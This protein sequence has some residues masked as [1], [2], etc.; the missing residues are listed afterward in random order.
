MCNINAVTTDDAIVTS[1]LVIYDVITASCDFLIVIY[2]YLLTHSAF[3]PFYFS[4]MYSHRPCSFMERPLS[5]VE[6]RFSKWF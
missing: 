4:Q 2:S 5:T 3:L 1:A 6:I